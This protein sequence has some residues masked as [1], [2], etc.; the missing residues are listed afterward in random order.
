VS[1]N[2]LA[3]FSSGG[4][5]GRIAAGLRAAVSAD[6]SNWH[7]ILRIAFSRTAKLAVP[8]VKVT[9]NQAVSK[10]K[11]ARMLVNAV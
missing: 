4:E 6:G 11:T 1:G 9:G 5:I 7:K 10:R 3:E 2:R 8:P